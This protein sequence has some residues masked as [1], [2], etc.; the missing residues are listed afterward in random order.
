MVLGHAEKSA[1]ASQSTGQTSGVVDHSTA[2]AVDHTATPAAPATATTA[3]P[4]AEILGKGAYS[5]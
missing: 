1:L 3:S 4:G 2:Q 5:T